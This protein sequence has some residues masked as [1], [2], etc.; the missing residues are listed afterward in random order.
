MENISLTGTNISFGTNCVMC[1]RCVYEC[2]SH[3]ILAATANFMVL[4]QGFNID[5]LEKRMDQVE[6]LPL[7]VCGKGFFR[8]SVK[9]YL[10][11]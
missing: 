7:E 6:L 1:F 3:S 8:K 10:S 2:P 9:S 5:R 11:E 4:K